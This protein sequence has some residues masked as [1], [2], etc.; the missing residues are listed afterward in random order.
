MNCD[1]YKRDM[2]SRFMELEPELEKKLKDY[3][4]RFR[5]RVE[6]EKE[7]KDYNVYCDAVYSILQLKEFKRGC[8]QFKF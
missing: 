2:E 1:N 7:L 6:M 8:I 4:G 3:E 5:R